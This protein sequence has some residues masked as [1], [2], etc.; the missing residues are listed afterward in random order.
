S[1][2]VLAIVPLW[3]AQTTGDRNVSPLQ[4][5]AADYLPFDKPGF[6]PDSTP[7]RRA[8]SPVVQSLYDDFLAHHQEQRL[9]NLPRTF[10]ARS[11]NLS[12]D[13]W[14]G[15]QLVLL[16]FFLMG[17]WTMGRELRFGLISA[18][19][20]FLAYVPYAYD[21]PWTMYYLEITPAIAAITAWGIWRAL[22]A[23][24]R[25]VVIQLPID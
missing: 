3:S 11:W 10:G 20:V 22:V 17:L 1:L 6:T 2:V 5:Y 24:V 25:G 16:P 7:P 15:T 12:L 14:R 8:L 21:A 9:E 13:L 19:L 18:V 4:V 23:M